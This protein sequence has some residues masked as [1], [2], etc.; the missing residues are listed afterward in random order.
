MEAASRNG[1][2]S[3]THLLR[4]TARCH[5]KESERGRDMGMDLV[6]QLLRLY[7]RIQC[8]K[9]EQRADDESVH[10]RGCLVRCRVGICGAL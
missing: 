3:R 7:S 5:G 6:G 10:D 4:R 1:H 9:K 8:A 2:S